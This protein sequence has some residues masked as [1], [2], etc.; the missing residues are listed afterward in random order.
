MDEQP[1]PVPRHGKRV[2]FRRP[3][4]AAVQPRRAA[5]TPTTFSASSSTHPTIERTTP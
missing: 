3:S 4:D 2:S 1:R 5:A